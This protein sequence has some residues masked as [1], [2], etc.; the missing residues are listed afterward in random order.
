[1]SR[2]RD[3]WR[4]I[5]SG[6]A[7]SYTSVVVPSITFDRDEL[8]KIQGVQ[9]Y[10]ER[11]LFCLVRLR[12]PR[13]R[14]VYLSSQ[15]IHPEIISYYLG[16]L[17]GVTTADAERRLLVLS[18][19]DGSP[20]PLT[21]KILDRPRLL[22]RIRRFVRD[23]DRAYLTCF[24]T[25]MLEQRLALELGIPLNGCDPSLAWIG[26]KAGS[27][28]VFERAGVRTPAG[29]DGVRTRADL[30]H[31][32]ESLADRV[33]KIRTAVVKL[34]DSFAGAGNALYR[35]PDPVPEGGT[36]RQI[37]LDAALRGLEPAAGETPE[38]Y[39]QKLE[40]MG[41]VV[42]Q[43]I[44]GE[45]VQSP[46]VQL[47]V[48]PEGG[49][50]VISTHDQVLDGPIGQT[51]VGCRFPADASYRASIRN[52]AL[53]VAEILTGE[54]VIGRFAIDF[55]VTGGGSAPL[56]TYAI[57]INLR[58]GG[59]TFPFM[60][61]QLLTGGK[62]DADTG[63]FHSARGETKAYFATDNLRSAAC[64]GL[65]PSDFLEIAGAHRLAFSTATETGPAFHMIGALS[66]YGRVGVTCIGGTPAEA[67]DMYRAVVATLDRE[68]GAAAVVPPPTHPM[69]LPIPSME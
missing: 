34:D 4:H 38:Q 14:I 64:A 8:A 54:G 46:S 22:E 41:G 23:P 29:V 35:F 28:R 44:E 43:Y 31:A 20:R 48:D 56:E 49:I 1:M 62:V 25:T 51:Y 33:P 47:R 40:R 16:L 37:A 66:Q 57:E 9:F 53:A 26:T 27:R 3:V 7:G 32:L 67:D 55:L 45:T 39:L 42:E 18:A 69:G 5:E 2:L 68:G 63:R 30:V 65:S 15:P 58:M 17:S 10:E 61:L 59:T 60:A 24:N 50:R 19:Y 36:E 12:D 6:Q 13:A 52:E 21:E 11:L